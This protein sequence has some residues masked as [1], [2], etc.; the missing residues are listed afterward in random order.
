MY[1][2]SE[3]AKFLDKQIKEGYGNWTLAI[4]R[5]GLDLR[6]PM[7]LHPGDSYAALNPQEKIVYLTARLKEQT[8]A[9]LRSK[10]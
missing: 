4:C 3:V 5:R 10:M 7:V 1:T 6:S 9:N 2:V 8:N